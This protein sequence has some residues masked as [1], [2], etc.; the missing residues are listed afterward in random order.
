MILPVSVHRGIIGTFPS[1]YWTKS[2]HWRGKHVQ[3]LPEDKVS[4]KGAARQ[5]KLSFAL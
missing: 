4:G 5:F 3:G 2:P 1:C